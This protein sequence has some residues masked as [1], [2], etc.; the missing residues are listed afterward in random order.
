[1]KVKKFLQSMN[2]WENESYKNCIIW[3]EL[4]KVNHHQ[5][6]A[7]NIKLNLPFER[8]CAA[9]EFLN[10]RA[11][12][13]DEQDGPVAHGQR[14]VAVLGPVPLERPAAGGEP[15]SAPACGGIR[16]CGGG[17]AP[18]AAAAAAWRPWRRH[19]DRPVGNWGRSSNGLGGRG[20]RGHRPDP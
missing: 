20:Y 13:E 4:K 15:P 14:L 1:M 10:A 17:R 11:A 5:F 19:E 3:I 7:S 6:W 18:A 8:S 2:D 16:P 9:D 12:G